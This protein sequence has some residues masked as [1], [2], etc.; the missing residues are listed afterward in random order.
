MGVYALRHFYFNFWIIV[1]SFNE[2]HRKEIR[3]LT[4]KVYITNI[5]FSR[6]CNIVFFCWNHSVDD[7]MIGAGFW[8]IEGNNKSEWILDFFNEF[9]FNLFPVLLTLSGWMLIYFLFHFVRGVRKE[10]QLK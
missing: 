7:N 1:L 6:T 10:E 3:D 5:F 4:K 2:D 9:F 8:K